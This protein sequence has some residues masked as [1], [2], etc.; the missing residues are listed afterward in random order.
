MF[1]VFF[2]YIISLKENKSNELDESVNRMELMRIT[3]AVFES[4]AQ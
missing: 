4:S 2:L 3:S 1:R